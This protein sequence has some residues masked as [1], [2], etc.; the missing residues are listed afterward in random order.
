MISKISI[1]AIIITILIIVLVALKLKYRSTSS[2]L[3]TR[4][5]F[6]NSALNLLMKYWTEGNVT[7]KLSNGNGTPSTCNK[8]LDV[9]V[10]NSMTEGSC[11]YV[12][13]LHVDRNN[14]TDSNNGGE[15]DTSE[16]KQHKSFWGYGRT[17][18]WK[19][20]S[21]KVDGV[22]NIQENDTGKVTIGTDKTSTSH[23]TNLVGG[24]EADK[25][26]V[27]GPIHFS[28]ADG[29]LTSLTDMN[30]KLSSDI[31]G[32]E[33]NVNDLINATEGSA[34]KQNVYFNMARE[35]LEDVDDKIKKTN[36]DLQTTKGDLN[37]KINHVDQTMNDHKLATS[38]EMRGFKDS[39][40]QTKGDLTQYVD[41]KVDT[42]ST[43]PSTQNTKVELNKG[44]DI[45]EGINIIGGKL[46]FKN[47]EAGDNDP[48]Y[49]QKIRHSH[50]NNEL[51]VTI[52]DNKDEALTIYGDSCRSPGGCFGPG[53]IQHKFK[54]DGK[55]FHR[56]AICISNDKMDTNDDHIYTNL[57][58]PDTACL[59]LDELKRL[60]TLAHRFDENDRKKLKGISHQAGYAVDGKQTTHLLFEGHHKLY[61]GENFDAWS[62]DSWD[63]LYVN[64][65]WK[66]TVWE[67]GNKQ[68][69][70][71]E[72][73]NTTS[74]TPLKMVLK[75]K[76]RVSEYEAT[77]INYPGY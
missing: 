42:L 69:F 41:T 59:G 15:F 39:L 55:S 77:W 22:V 38:D 62:N 10:Q 35:K 61:G 19:I 56:S 36:D 26:T 3:S 33:S 54:A 75:S 30:Q 32:L 70:K 12:Y 28:S 27:R 1:A 68:G 11:P 7:E 71:Q 58:D 14:L 51:R 53:T 57:Q 34:Y 5:F 2:V 47:S 18:D 16:N 73:E 46:Q 65:G 8:L 48:Y 67:H 72:F 64:K 24:L 63:V 66:V 25:L 20:N 9:G 4:T 13:N 40:K 52:N 17:L 49:I 60:H 6:D 74:F 37:D 43:S 29:N 44:V 23:R 21:G 50:D 76:N 45:R 31:S